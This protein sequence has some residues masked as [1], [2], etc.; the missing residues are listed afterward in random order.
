MSIYNSKE[1]QKIIICL[2]NVKVSS[3]NK[4]NDSLD[5]KGVMETC[6][7]VDTFMLIFG[8]TVATGNSMS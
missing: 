8:N 2:K 6:R 4:R 7:I 5:I 1:I 3:F